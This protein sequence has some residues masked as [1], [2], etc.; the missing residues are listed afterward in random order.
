MLRI[1][2]NV[3][4]LHKQGAQG[5]PIAIDLKHWNNCLTANGIDCKQS[6]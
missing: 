3:M 6:H 2:R 4:S 1:H 5:M